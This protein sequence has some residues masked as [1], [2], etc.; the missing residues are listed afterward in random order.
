MM[1]KP[2]IKLV[3]ADDEIAKLQKKLNIALKA[4]NFYTNDICSEPYIPRIA[5]QALK[6]IDEVGTSEK[7]EV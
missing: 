4:L 6:E 1:N 7:E 2:V 3:L 5:I